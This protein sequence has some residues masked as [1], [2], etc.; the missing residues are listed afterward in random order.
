[1]RTKFG[2]KILPVFLSFLLLIGLL[3]TMAFAA[4]NMESQTL[5]ISTA[6]QLVA[7]SKAV[8]TGE[9]DENAAAVVSLTADIDMTGMEW[10]PIG[11]SDSQ[12]NIEHAFS[13]TFNG[14]GHKIY[15]LDFAPTYGDGMLQGLFGYVDGGTIQNVTVEGTA[16]LVNGSKMNPV[17]F[18]TVAAY[19]VNTKIINCT[20]DLVFDNHGFAFNGSYVG[21]I[22]GY[23][24]AS[25]I[26]RCANLGQFTF[27]KSSGVVDVYVG[28]IC[29]LAENGSIVSNCWDEG[30]AV[31]ATRYYGGISANVFG[32]S[33]VLNCYS[34]G[35][36][37]PVCKNM[38]QNY[39]GIVGGLTGSASVK[40]CYFSGTIDTSEYQN[41][42][43]PCFVGG[44]VGYVQSVNNQTPV[45]EN[46]YSRTQTTTCGDLPVYGNVEDGVLKTQEEMLS[47][48]FVTELNAGGGN[49]SFCS[50]A[51]PVIPPL[52]YTI[53][54]TGGEGGTASAN[55]TSASAG[56][57]IS[58]SVSPADGYHFKEW[59]IEPA[60]VIENNQFIMP[61][62]DVNIT[63]VFENHVYNQEIADEKY[64]KSAADC[65]TPAIY[66]KSCI[67]GAFS[68]TAGT[69]TNGEATGHDWGD[70]AWNWSEDG[71]TATAVFTCKNDSSHTVRPEVTMT[72]KT[73][74]ATCTEDGSIIYIA[75][76]TLEGT[77]Y[78]VSNPVSIAAT[79][80]SKTYYEAVAPTCTTD[81][82]IEY[83]YCSNCKKYFSDEG[84]QNVINKEDTVDEATGHSKE[85]HAAVAPTATEPG[86]IE[87][88]YCS[89]CDTYFADEALTKV[90][91]QADTILA[92]T[93]GQE[94]SKLEE[95]TPTTPSEPPTDTTTPTGGDQ[96]GDTNA[97]QTGDD[98][99]IALWMAVML[100][101]GTAL[102][103]TLLY[104]RKK[105][106]SK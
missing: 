47:E 61:Y 20:S 80:H 34:T 104:S 85:H 35:I 87:Y 69:F 24:I 96:T 81:G 43:W 53:T 3:P 42:N 95:S 75:S 17:Y 54:I 40:S 70:P 23:A 106:C 67:C 9:Y 73:T 30:D 50:G 48:A 62:D 7:F 18:G 39:A 66:Y 5:E 55:A 21:G 63:A 105:K 98:S 10:T 37:K 83:W 91:S 65:E 1:M 27:S 68:E 8:N 97:P 84:C 14:N 12:G 33:H 94:P 102:T 86:N 79:G 13:G 56:T 59:N 64:L 45:Y 57:E 52:T 101:A 44:I 16:Y 99:H 103:G 11:K 72:E 78:T 29:A 28:G 74:S 93:G 76:V 89:V 82:N 22:C 88:W 51:T 15:N 71:T 41:D 90:I 36:I 32:D 46:N 4:E 26:D 25:S 77:T 92:P 31:V 2:K 19:A 49:Y 58:L 100:A 38:A 6:E 60:V